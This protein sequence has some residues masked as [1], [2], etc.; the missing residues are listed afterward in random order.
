[1]AASDA[2]KRLQR[3]WVSKLIWPLAALGLLLLFNLFFGRDSFFTLKWFNGHLNG[4]MIDILRNGSLVMLLSLGM[5]LV[6]ATGGVDLS[7]GS[8]MALAAAV[9]AVL[10]AE[11]CSLPVVLAA[12]L[13]ACLLAGA[14]NGMLVS[15]FRV[16]PLVATLVMMVAGRGVA[17]LLCQSSGIKIP[18]TYVHHVAFKYIGNEFLF[19]V[20]VA[21]SVVVAM[22][23]L[24][25]V[26]TRKT[27][28]GLFIEAVGD[29]DTASRYAGINARVV[30]LTVYAFSGLCA[31]IAGLIYTSNVPSPLVAQ[32]GL[33]LELDAIMAVVIGGTALTGGRFF[34]L[35]S[36]VGALLIQTLTTTMISLEMSQNQVLVP[37]ALVVVAVCLLQSP[38]FRQKLVRVFRM[39]WPGRA[40]E[41]AK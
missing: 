35:G 19:Y 14:W 33:Y 27:A 18:R 9:I 23:V 4:T 39:I 12:A 20:P 5:T 26:L 16:Q 1:M 41:A 32:M 37:K 40:R 7:V 6:I 28:L 21:I 34:L 3:E 31:G 11:G 15:V 22:F 17:M 36:I 25:A 30:K 2:P 8:V 38:A 24:T 29:N 10:V 13:G